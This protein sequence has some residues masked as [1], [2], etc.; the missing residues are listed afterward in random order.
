MGRL[1]LL[2]I[3]ILA[4][5]AFPADKLYAFYPTIVRSQIIQHNLMKACPNAEV[6]VFGRYND[7]VAKIALDS[8]E[9][10]ITKTMVL[11]QMPGYSIKAAGSF[12]GSDAEPYVILSVNEKLDP[13]AATAETTIGIIDFLGRKEM[14]VFIAQF[15]STAPKLKRVTKIED[16]LPLLTFNMAQGVL[17][18]EREVSYFKETSNLNFV[19]T[20]TKFRVGIVAL[21]VKNGTSSADIV[22]AIKTLNAETSAMLGATQWK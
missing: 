1:F 10:I 16:L 7:F 5:Q 3:F 12:K 11:A 13:S 8:P 18:S 2:A 14:A 9:A 22:K 17:I 20:P 19:I 6:M 21:S 4:G 15:F